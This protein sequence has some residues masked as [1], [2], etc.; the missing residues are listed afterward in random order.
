MIQ[1][2]EVEP[3]E[4]FSLD[5]GP[6]IVSPRTIPAET[7]ATPTIPTAVRYP[8]YEIVSDPKPKRIVEGGPYRTA[9][10]LEIQ[11]KRDRARA[12]RKNAKT[13]R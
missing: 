10:D 8:W 4:S 3:T 1:F 12:R 11:K 9:R 6:V 2:P 5:D 13:K 7:V